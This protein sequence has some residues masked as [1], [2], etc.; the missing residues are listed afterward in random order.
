MVCAWVAAGALV[1]CSAPKADS[2]TH[3]SGTAAPKAEK[4]APDSKSPAAAPKP[5]TPPGEFGIE[6]A[7]AG[8]EGSGALMVKFETNQG[9]IVAK[10][11]EK[12]A[13][14][15]VANF[16]GLARGLKEFRDPKTA[17][18]AKRPFYDGLVFHRVIP[19]FMIQ[20][21]DPTGTGRGGPGYKFADEFHPE[22]RHSKPGILSMANA[23]P[24]TNGSQF[25]ITEAPTKH[26]NNRHSV[27]GEV[28]EGLDVVKKIARVPTQPPAN[29]PKEDVVMEK[30]TIYRQ[31][32]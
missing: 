24:N 7:V 13:P 2:E 26:L 10:L 6:Q 25:F 31:D 17:E 30:V 28:V 3:K 16:V 1:A 9:V 8:L 23:G 4:K 32:A 5:A 15:T 11:F 29:R 18:K 19:N 27:F 12:R 21:G 20:G 14:K 22:L